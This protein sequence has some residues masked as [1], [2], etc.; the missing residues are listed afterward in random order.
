MPLRSMT[1]YGMADAHVSGGR[2]RVEI[3][4]VNHKS[5][6]VRLSVPKGFGEFEQKVSQ[7]IRE[8]LARGRVSVTCEYRREAASAGCE[9]ASALGIDEARFGAVVKQLQGLKARH[10]LTGVIGFAE[11]EPYAHLFRKVDGEDRVEDLLGWE[12]VSAVL[13]EALDRF[14]QARVEEGAGIAK[15]FEAHLEELEERRRALEALR[16]QLLEGYH[17]RLRERLNALV[18]AH[19]GHIEPERVVNEVHHFAEKTDIAEELQRAHAHIERLQ[20]LI[21]EHEGESIGKKLDFYLQEMIRETNTMASKSNFAELTGHVIE[22]KSRVEQ[23]REQSANV[24]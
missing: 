17:E 24:E 3:K 12:E 21:A 19:G 6:D 22:M 1:G 15:M 16:P 7:Q 23:L 13:D 2:L 4:S 10:G 20:R 9:D 8:R 14:D 18:E 5:L 11:L